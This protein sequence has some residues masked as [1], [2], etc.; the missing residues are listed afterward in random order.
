MNNNISLRISVAGALLLCIPLQ[1]CI[2]L[3]GHSIFFIS[4]YFT[5][6]DRLDIHQY[7]ANQ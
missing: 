1:G 6:F 2:A 4:A 3:A 5:F 7:G